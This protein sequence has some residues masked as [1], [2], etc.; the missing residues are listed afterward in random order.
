MK[1]LVLTLLL[2]VP[3]FICGSEG[4]N[5][6][7]EDRDSYG[8]SSVI[9]LR[10]EDGKRSFIVAEQNKKPWQGRLQCQG[11]EQAR[12]FISIGSLYICI[13]LLEKSANPQ[14]IA[15]ALLSRENKNYIA[16]S[17]IYLRRVK[18]S[19]QGRHELDLAKDLSIQARQ[20]DA[21]TC[22]D[23][24]KLAEKEP[25]RRSSSSG[26][27]EYVNGNASN[28]VAILSDILL[29]DMKRDLF[30]EGCRLS[31][32]CRSLNTM[33]TKLACYC[34]EEA[35]LGDAIERLAIESDEV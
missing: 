16:K 24:G 19:D 23:P 20:E 17:C 7:F 13:G 15:C 12:H 1:K 10:Q 3:Y 25:V 27:L 30:S 2:A 31:K 26:R 6:R 18:D 5:R 4:I 29:E 35:D 28:R 9:L 14:W 32:D 11:Y 33:T 22:G 8:R 34:Y 21:K